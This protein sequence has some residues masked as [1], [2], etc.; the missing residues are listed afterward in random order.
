M[1]DPYEESVDF[2]PDV[3]D[4]AFL[5]AADDDGHVTE[6]FRSV[7]GDEYAGEFAPYSFATRSVLTETVATLDLSPGQVLVD[8][9]CGTG[10]PGLWL[11]RESGAKLIGIDWSPEAIRQANR[12]NAVFSPAGGASFHVGLLTDTG[13]EDESADAVVC[14]DAF[15]F[16]PDPIECVSEIARILRSGG[17]F[18]MSGWNFMHSDEG[19]TVD[20]AS[21]VA[22]GGL[23]VD[24]YT[25]RPDLLA[26]EVAIFEAAARAE[27]GKSRALDNL[28]EE[29]EGALH[30]TRD[31][32]RILLSAHKPHNRT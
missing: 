23:V 32:H 10:G 28:K 30:E 12:R 13:L 2:S 27:S 26:F 1:E 19:R 5:D 16:A 21:I 11:A 18:M 3:F 17:R 25:F 22:A 24:S 14:Y 4:Q 20:L 31:V 9:A 15:Q 29:A 6:V 7:M 8:L